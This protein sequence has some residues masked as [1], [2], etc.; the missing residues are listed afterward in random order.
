MTQGG[1]A[2]PDTK[3]SWW[4]R[5]IL[6]RP[7]NDFTECP[8]SETLND[9]I[10]VVCSKCNTILIGI[11]LSNIAKSLVINFLRG[12]A[13]VVAFAV[14]YLNWTWPT[15]ALSNILVIMFFSLFLRNHKNTRNFFFVVSAFSFIGYGVWKTLNP[16][17]PSF[18]QVIG[19]LLTV[20]LVLELLFLVLY[21]LRTSSND[22]RKYWLRSNNIDLGSSTLTWV[23]LTLTITL[24]CILAV[25]TNLITPT[26]VQMF[27]QN[28]N[29]NSFALR[30]ALLAFSATQVAALISS[31]VYSLK[32]HPFSVL[33][34]WTYKP[35][36]RKCDFS[37]VHVA[38]HLDAITWTLRL[39]HS[40]KRFAIVASNRII[41]GIE[42][43][44]NYFIVSFLNNLARAA[45]KITNTIRCMIIKTI[46]HIIRS[47]KRFI[48]LNKWC[49]KWAWHVGVQYAKVFMLP[50]VLFIVSTMLLYSI[51][52]DFFSYVHDDSAFIPII[53]FI[54][55]LAL[56][57]L[58]TV[59]TGFL[60][61]ANLLVFFEKTLNALSIFG[62]SAFLFFV[63]S[64]WL[65]GIIGM[66]TSGPYRIG[67]VT[68][69]STLALVS[70]F[71]LS[72]RR[73][74][75]SPDSETVP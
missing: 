46:R 60:S 39:K 75:T 13:V 32:G 48:L 7:R 73:Q 23:T 71:F 69:L 74:S 54:K 40:I 37:R 66:L 18:L 19:L 12:A 5:L 43:A 50:L 25:V 36:L 59:G 49:I 6:E 38:Q 45:I 17:N 33:D 22:F 8:S 24:F 53:I 10:D 70:V 57:I 14:G 28:N 34:R 11:Q 20:L 72:K 21:T 4:E 31:T 30:G 68:I 62:T 27:I 16:Q 67:W 9:S 2:V 1:R 61:H 55:S 44:Y 41:Q 58:F 29:F 65:L 64:A 35:I 47:L 42:N 52:D 3:L 56:I 26:F 15:F 51:S 63:L